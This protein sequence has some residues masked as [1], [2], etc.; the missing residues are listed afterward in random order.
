MKF[1]FKTSWIGLFLIA[2]MLFSTFAY[3]IIQRFNSGENGQLPKSNIIN[4]QLDDN[5]KNAFIQYGVTMITFDYNLGCENCVAQK[6]T[7]EFFANEYK[8]NLDNPKLS[9]DDVY[10][11]IFLEEI[12][13]EGLDK[14]KTKI[15]SAYGEDEMIDA[16][17]TQI[18]NSLCKLMVSPPVACA[19][20]N[21]S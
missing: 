15:T 3:A 18:V 20:K 19:I 2:V 21:L 8:L 14:S 4:Y 9:I 13:D 12:L 17:E 10:G 16:N 1:K 11:K 7:L 6:S 5:L